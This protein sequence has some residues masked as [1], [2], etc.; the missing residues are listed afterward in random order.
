MVGHHEGSSELRAGQLSRS[1]M[2]N[3]TKVSVTRKK[4]NLSHFNVT[5]WGFYLR[6]KFRTVK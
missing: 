6:L 1:E 4:Q 3:D 2:G 5:I